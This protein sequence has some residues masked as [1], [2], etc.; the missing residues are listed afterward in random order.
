VLGRTLVTS[1]VNVLSATAKV[2]IATAVRTFSEFTA[3]NDHVWPTR[4]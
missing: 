2:Q 1:G 4:Q 3:D